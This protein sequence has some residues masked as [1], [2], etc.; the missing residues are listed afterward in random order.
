MTCRLV[1]SESAV[2]TRLRENK[3]ATT[4]RSKM[5][6]GCFVVLKLFIMSATS[7]S[8]LKQCVSIN[9]DGTVIIV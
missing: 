9:N 6:T 5:I 1:I 2:K 8:A 3:L 4:L 7:N